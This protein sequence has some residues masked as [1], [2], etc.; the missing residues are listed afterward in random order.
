M[1]REKGEERGREKE[2]EREREAWVAAKYNFELSV[3]DIVPFM[4]SYS[5]IP[6]NTSRFRIIAHVREQRSCRG[7]NHRPP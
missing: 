7:S 3:L 2:G 6:M 5:Q 4:K 1:E